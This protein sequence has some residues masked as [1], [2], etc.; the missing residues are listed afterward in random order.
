[1]RGTEYA[2]VRGRGYFSGNCHMFPTVQLCTFLISKFLLH[3]L[4]MEG[5]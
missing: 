4:V 1:M 3:I 2:S 5:R